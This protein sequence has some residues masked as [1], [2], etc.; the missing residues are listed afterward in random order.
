MASPTSRM[1]RIISSS[2]MGQA[3][4]ESASCAALMAWETPPTLR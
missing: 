3:T 4:P 1:V 2:E